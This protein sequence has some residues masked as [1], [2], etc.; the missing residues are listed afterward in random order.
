M[1]NFSALT[2]GLLTFITTII[3]GFIALKFKD[4]I[5]Y[6]I[7]FSGGALVAAATVHLIPESLEILETIEP[8]TILLYTLGS[9]LFFHLIDK[10]INIHGHSHSEDCEEHTN[11]FG[12]IPPLGLI[13][14]SFLDG[15]SIGTGFLVNFEIGVLISTVVLL[16]DFA[17][18]MNTVTLLLRAKVRNSYVILLLL[19]GALAPVIGVLTSF[20]VRPSEEILGYILALYAGFFLH[21]GATD[22]LPEAHKERSSVILVMFT[23]VGA[24]IIG[25]L[26][27]VG[28]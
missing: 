21:L 5:K 28:H 24:A 18:G 12:I 2:I 3:G 16:H 14:H 15:L 25:G 4:Y 27:I 9:F 20:V 6:L 26:S 22:L 11:K 1:F 13:F 7:A 10:L 23:I 8:H 17:D 19:V